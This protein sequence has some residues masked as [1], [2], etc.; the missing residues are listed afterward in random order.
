MNQNA[1]PDEW[2]NDPNP[3]TEVEEP[4][5]DLS[6]D[7]QQECGPEHALALRNKRSTSLS[8]ARAC[9]DR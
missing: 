8:E 3:K 6:E 2:N 9:S 4:K 1:Y 7:D 5:R